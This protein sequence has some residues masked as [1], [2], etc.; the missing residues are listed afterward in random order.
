MTDERRQDMLL[1]ALVVSIVAHVALMV[2]MKPQVM[3][4]VS[5][6]FARHRARGP[7]AVRDVPPPAE[8]VAMAAV[9]DVE[10]L[11]ESPEAR[12]FDPAPGALDADSGTGGGESAPEVRPP[13]AL[14]APEPS[15]EVAPFLSEKLHVDRDV[16]SFSTAVVEKGAPLPAPRLAA[17]A[18][19][20]AD[21]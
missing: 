4:Q 12:V 8:S 10:A 5:G 19:S 2:Y 13:E 20:G 1:A 17:P 3:A 18:A 16:P 14:P 15:V 6:D 21:A 7:M 11:R 9:R